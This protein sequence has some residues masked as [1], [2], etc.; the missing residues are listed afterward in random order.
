ME[1]RRAREKSF[2]ADLIQG[3]RITASNTRG[4]AN[5]QFGVRHLT[6]GNFNTYWAAD[7]N[8]TQVSFEIDLR[9]PTAFNRVQL[10]EYIP[11]GQR[12]KSFTI[13]IWNDDTNSWQQVAS[14]TTIGY[15]RI[16]RF[17]KVTAQRLR[18]NIN[19]SLAS[20]VLN[21]MAIFD[22]TEFI[23]LPQ[24]TRNQEGI[25]TIA[26]PMPDPVI[27]HTTDGTVPTVAS[28]RFETPFA[29]LQGGVVR[30][31]AMIDNNTQQSEVITAN[32]DIAAAK[33]TVLSPGQEDAYRAID[34]N[35]TNRVLVDRA[36]PF[37]IDLGET[38]HLRGFVY[39]P[40]ARTTAP[41]IYRYNFSVSDDN[42]QWRTVMRNAT[43]DNIRNSPVAQEVIF[44][45]PVQARY[46]RLEALELA[47]PGD[48]YSLSEVSVITR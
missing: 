13:D 5:R 34:G 14:E 8:I 30:A 26:T 20:P 24:I 4:D 23:T 42:R 29:M 36:Q 35:L 46:I 32:F 37:I 28:P 33:W 48:R 22:A 45:T 12:V 27:F 1:F 2:A 15:K 7:D 16:V 6:D 47:N 38:L 39:T 17:T 19:E 18:V 40:F 9:R 31:V 21:G 10:Q 25:V 11:L 43:F 3:A 44:D 41:N